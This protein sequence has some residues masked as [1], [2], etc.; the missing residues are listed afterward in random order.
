M[1]NPARRRRLSMT[2]LIDVI[3][4]LLLFFMLSSTFSRFSE[5][6]ISA[7]G[8]GGATESETQMSF[9]QLGENS[10]R[11]NGEDID[12]TNLSQEFSEIA[13]DAETLRV[14]VSLRDEVTAQRLTDVLVVLRGIDRL[15]I[16]VLGS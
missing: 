11:M 10:L 12:L 6:E 3:F 1:R 9:L 7:A 5:V 13:P 8:S 14:L 2:S 4:L 16:N 15:N